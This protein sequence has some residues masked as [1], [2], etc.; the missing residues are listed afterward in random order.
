M[1]L[2]GQLEDR[3]RE[4]ERL[5]DEN[6]TLTQQNERLQE[7]VDHL[8]QYAHCSLDRSDTIAHGGASVC[9][10]CY[11]TLTQEVEQAHRIQG[12][13]L[14][15]MSE[16]KRKMR[17]EQ[18][19]LTQQLADMREWA[20]EADAIL[21]SADVGLSSKWIDVADAH[22]RRYVALQAHAAPKEES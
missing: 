17:D 16:L 22:H 1:T 18:N 3:D 9:Q 4:I 11:N 5:R 8:S 7:Q 13:L 21:N 15:D 6:A 19:V 14:A 2:M 10:S 12:A 20:Q